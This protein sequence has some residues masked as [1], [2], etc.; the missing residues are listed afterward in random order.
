MCKEILSAQLYLFSILLQGIGLIGMGQ[1]KGV[2]QVR[3]Q[4]F[5]YW[6]SLIDRS[7]IASVPGTQNTGS[8]IECLCEFF[9]NL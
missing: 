9:G 2:D 6:L 5:L 4:S 7:Q 1:E 8:L 3:R